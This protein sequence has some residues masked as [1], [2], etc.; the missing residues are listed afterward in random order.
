MAELRR[1][2]KFGPR[3]TFKCKEGD[4]TIKTISPVGGK[5]K[6]PV[7]TNEIEDKM[8]VKLVGD[9]LIEPCVKTDTECLGQVIGNPKFANGLQPTEDAVWGEYDPRQVTVECM[10]SRIDE[11]QLEAANAEIV[12]WNSVTF[13]AT[14][15][16]TFDK[17]STANTTRALHGATANSG[18]KIPV[19]FGFNGTL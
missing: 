4:M 8:Y 3:I 1:F 9:M 5:I 15:N 13:G 2:G 6:G 17:D 7:F 16:Q 18:G 11:V 14:T 10:G 12:F 19:L